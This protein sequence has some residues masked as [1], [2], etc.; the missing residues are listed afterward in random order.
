MASWGYGIFDND[1]AENWTE[2][3]IDDPKPK[4]VDKAFRKVMDAAKFISIT[5][6]EEALAAAELV[7]G[8]NKQPSPDLPASARMFLERYNIMATPE[9]KEMAIKVVERIRDKSEVK[10]LWTESG[11]LDPWLEVVDDLLERLR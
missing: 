10:E 5:D 7:A 1:T 6:C 9:L 11:D 2:A 4:V 8:L 3:F